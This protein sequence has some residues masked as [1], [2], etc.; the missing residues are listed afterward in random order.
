MDA[1]LRDLERLVAAGDLSV[2]PAFMRASQRAGRRAIETVRVVYNA[3]LQLGHVA[4]V[5]LAWAALENAGWFRLEPEK[6]GSWWVWGR[7]PE[8]RTGWPTTA[9]SAIRDDLPQDAWDAVFKDGGWCFDAMSVDR[10]FLERIPGASFRLMPESWDRAA[11]QALDTLAKDMD[12][13]RLILYVWREPDA[14]AVTFQWA[15][16]DPFQSW[17][18]FGAAA[19]GSRL[20]RMSEE[21][22]DRQIKVMV[23]RAEQEGYTVDVARKVSPHFAT[24]ERLR[25]AAS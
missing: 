13:T 2:V 17:Q 11:M 24:A 22:I 16:V 7:G 19:G 4:A 9:V 10:E 3:Q 5:E 15:P 12:R 6:R 25:R 18:S 1:E 14:P 23:D 20:G 21:A 8:P